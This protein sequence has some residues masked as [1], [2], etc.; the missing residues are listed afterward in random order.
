MN[1]FFSHHMN[2][3]NCTEGSAALG[4]LDYIISDLSKNCQCTVFGIGSLR[5][6]N[7]INCSSTLRFTST[8]DTFLQRQSDGLGW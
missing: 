2:G 7:V 4:I 8:C 5:D 1:H 3:I 6:P